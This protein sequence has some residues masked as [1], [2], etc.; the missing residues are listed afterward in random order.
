MNLIID[1]EAIR[2]RAIQFF[3]NNIMSATE[4]AAELK[5]AYATANRWLAH[6]KPIRTKTAQ[7]IDRYL[8]RKGF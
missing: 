5:I 7:L 8:Q 6:G 1:Q 4:F 2:L 3:K